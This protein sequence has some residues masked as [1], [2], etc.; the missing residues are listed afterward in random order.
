VELVFGTGAAV[1]ATEQLRRTPPA[2]T[3][4]IWRVAT[5]SDSA[6]LKV[7]G[8]RAEGHPR[9]PASDDPG[10]PY[11]WRREAL[12]YTSGLLDRLSGG[13][14]APACRAAVERADG[15]VALWLE[16]VPEPSCWTPGLLT[17]VARRLGVAQAAFAAALP[18]EPWLSRDWLRLYLELHDVV[19]TEGVLDRLD[20]FPHTLCHH[21][22]H[23]GNVLGEDATVVVDWAYCGLAPLG[24]DAGVLV[25]D[26]IADS[27][28]A[29]E[30][31]GD[32]AAA[33]WAGYAAGLADGGWE[34][35]LDTVRW[36]YLRGTALRL[37]WLPVTHRDVP[38][39]ETQLHEA[40]PATI[41]LLDRWRDE[42]RELA[43]AL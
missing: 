23:P 42:A 3:L 28:L 18:T 27:V 35:P 38:A 39:T 8:R 31:A 24:L 34:G 25:A 2:A 19:D 14:R 4:G 5:G 43:S 20:A 26:G 32:A 29:P 37:S 12:A 16:D 9:W 17:E 41:A 33:V 1:S 21:D 10:H 36:A 15:S 30:L 40:W 13:L 6:V 11:Y 22:L 7:V